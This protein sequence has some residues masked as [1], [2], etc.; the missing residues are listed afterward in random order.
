MASEIHDTHQRPWTLAP[1]DQP[2]GK[3][4]T[5][6]VAPDDRSLDFGD[7]M[8]ELALTLGGICAVFLAII[9]VVKLIVHS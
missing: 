1:S 3:G 5:R 4:P 2:W 6:R 9:L 7:A 8:R